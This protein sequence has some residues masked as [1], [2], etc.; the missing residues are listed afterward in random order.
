LHACAAARQATV[1]VVHL[2]MIVKRLK[3]ANLTLKILN[4]SLESLLFLRLHSVFGAVFMCEE[5]NVF[6]SST[7]LF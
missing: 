6:F 4:V 3:D 1:I 2:I 7:E 5:F